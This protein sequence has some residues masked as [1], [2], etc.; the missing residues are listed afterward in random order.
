M[1]NLDNDSNSH[2]LGHVIGPSP[3]VPSA[4][5]S[6]SNGKDFSS[7]GDLLLRLVRHSLALFLLGTQEAAQPSQRIRR[8][9]ES[10]R[11]DGLAAGDDAV[12][13]ALLVLAA[14]GAEGVILGLAG[15]AEWI[16]GIV[17]HGALDLGRVLLDDGEGLVDPL[18]ALVGHGVGPVHHWRHVPVW[19]LGIGQD[20]LDEGVETMLG[21][22]DG[23]PAERIALDGLD[24]VVDDRVRGEMLPG[25]V[26]CDNPPPEGMFCLM[27]GGR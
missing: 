9:D 27:R 1:P 2:D 24:G 18:E 12:S 23:F 21:E 13:A 6:E 26:S 17:Q 15:Q 22:V 25:K 10:G 4:I 3:V 14:V 5:C 16:E 11:D 7:L 20:G 19:L 8:H